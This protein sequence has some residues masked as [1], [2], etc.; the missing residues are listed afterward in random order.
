M[1]TQRHHEKTAVL[2]LKSFTY[3]DIDSVCVVR[4]QLLAN[5]TVEYST[6]GRYTGRRRSMATLPESRVSTDNQYV[7]LLEV[8]QALA[9]HKSLPELFHDLARRLH[10][11][12]NFTYLSLIL[13]DPVED[14]MR[15]HTLHSENK[16]TIQPGTAF[17]M[18][19]S[20]SA[21]VW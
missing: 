19:E 14:V 15:L 16:A 8:S 12:L 11:V 7:T 18:T 10:T 13:H 1:A 17:S 6:V 5:P 3:K 2:V 9:N 20:P 4:R 21:E